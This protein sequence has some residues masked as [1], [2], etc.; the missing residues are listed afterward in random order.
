MN[1]TSRHKIFI[2][3][4]RQDS[5][6]RAGRLYDQLQ[7][8][9]G[10]TFVFMDRSDIP[11]GDDFRDTIRQSLATS[12]ICLVI[13]GKTWVSATDSHGRRRLDNQND[14]VRLEIA[15]AIRERAR[16]IPLL[17]DGADMP[18]DLPPALESLGFKHA[19]S[20]HDDGWT[21]DVNRLIAMLEA[22]LEERKVRIPARR[23]IQ[24]LMVG[25][26]A[27]AAVL[28]AAAV[29]WLWPTTSE[30]PRPVPSPPTEA[31]AVIE[32]A[33]HLPLSLMYSIRE[34]GWPLYWMS[35]D[36]QNPSDRPMD[37]V[38][39]RK[40]DEP[41]EGGWQEVE[42]QTVDGKGRLERAIRK[43]PKIL[44]ADFDDEKTVSVAWRIEHDTGAVNRT[45]DIT[46]IPRNVLPWDL[47]DPHGQPLERER[48]VAALAGWAISPGKARSVLAPEI[49]AAVKAG[50]PDPAGD[51]AD[52]WYRE[53][54][55]RLF[56]RCGG[57]ERVNVLAVSRP[58]PDSVSQRIEFSDAV[59]EAGTA[60]PLEAVLLVASL[61]WE[62]VT[63]RYRIPSVLFARVNDTASELLF[64]W[65][66]DSW[67][68]LELTAESQALSFEH[69]R[70]A[71]S[72]KLA[73]WLEGREGNLQ[74]DL[75][76]TGVFVTEEA[77]ETLVALDFDN[78]KDHFDVVAIPAG[79]SE[80]GAE[81]L[82]VYAPCHGADSESVP[83][84]LDLSPIDG[85]PFQSTSLDAE[86]PGLVPP[87]KW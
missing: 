72:A 28:S 52:L 84:T 86:D 18:S 39:K 45:E 7:E 56:F 3:Y 79:R 77:G 62:E 26:A 36:V 41:F 78:A 34:G 37:V 25:G 38:V 30:A 40:A 75:D 4:R 1:G 22:E 60:T 76:E 48:L 6:G 49:T 17:V 10:S 85:S 57:S 47:T 71:A 44:T 15:S 23:A 43:Y 83:A 74:R 69:N 70:A 42:T 81:L 33:S 64:G 68:A 20:I 14:Y 61:G 87:V 58:L 46:L 54:Y 66:A 16:V 32:P 67:S 50:S 24:R 9:F 55:D 35:Y 31:R 80:L 12:E 19:F 27:A 29:A 8:R 63:R 73:T 65:S 5:G 53:L 2:S 51:F 59:L 11:P 21:D 82:E 13:I